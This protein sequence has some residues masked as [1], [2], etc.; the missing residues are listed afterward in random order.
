V[1]IRRVARALRR[2]TIL[3]LVCLAVALGGAYVLTEQETPRYESTVR[4]VVSAAA[5]PA[6]G[7]ESDGDESDGAGVGAGPISEERATTYA[8]VV[9]SQVLA[10]RVASSLLGDP[11]YR[12]ESDLDGDVLLEQVS[13]R[14]VPG[15]AVLEIRVTDPDP[16]AAQVIA[17]TFAEELIATATDI[18][19][20]GLG[21]TEDPGFTVIDFASFD[22][23]PVSP[24]P[25]TALLVAAGGGLLL[26]LI[27]T[28]LRE[29]LMT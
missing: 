7:A 20:G 17:Q 23:E 24:Q 22:D 4:V 28:G 15:S 25:L 21:T 12:G 16:A 11:A 26:G 9:T 19:T 10:S 29:A 14:A 13:A 27:L 3:I 18:E 1:F 5:A 8:E 6:D 2:N